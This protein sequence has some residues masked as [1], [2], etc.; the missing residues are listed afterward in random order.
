MTVWTIGHGARTLA[1]LLELLAAHAIATLVD[2]RRIPRSRRHPQ[3]GRERLAAALEA[4]GVRYEHRA[5]LG[6]MREPD[7]SGR[8]AGLREPA[9][10]GYADYM[11]TAAFAA[12]LD[13]LVAGAG[14]RRTAILC[15]ESAPEACHRSL[16]ADALVARGVQVEHIVTGGGSRSHVLS[17][18]A[19]TSG[20]RVA[21]PSL[22]GELG[23]DES[24]P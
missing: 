2:V 24:D 1:E 4:A 16:I 17:R 9:F 21:Y 22:Q 15:A 3:F 10:R 19:R 5:G 23:V 7:G 12:E 14:G 18:T 11:Q 20:D 13:A 6:G 8:N